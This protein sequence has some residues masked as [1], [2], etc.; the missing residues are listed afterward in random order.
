M[1]LCLNNIW[2]IR[3]EVCM[4]LILVILS[5]TIHWTKKTDLLMFR[6]VQI[7]GKFGAL[8][9]HYICAVGLSVGKYIYLLS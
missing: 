3:F 8:N 2:A 1:V 6:K 7:C 4:N 5:A 9:L